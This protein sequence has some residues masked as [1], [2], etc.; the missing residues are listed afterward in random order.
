[1]YKKTGITLSIVISII[2]LASCAEKIIYTHNNVSYESPERALAAQKASCG[3]LLSKVNPTTNPVGGVTVM[4]LPSKTYIRNNLLVYKGPETSEESREK[5]R[6]FTAASAIAGWHC[7]GEAIEKRRIFDK[8]IFTSSDN[9]ESAS[10]SEDFAILKFKKDNQ[11]QYFIRKKNNAAE[12][13]PVEEISTAMPP[14]QR[15]N[16][17]L[18]N[19][20]KA[21]RG[22]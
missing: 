20:E 3:L 16:L 18:D 5:M 13:I 11:V 6:E 19:I 17:W 2:V 8:V 14:V 1:M 21:T 7:E 12:I 4:I 9:P 10:F 15:L 22:K